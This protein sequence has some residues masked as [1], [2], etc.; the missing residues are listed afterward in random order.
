M[1]VLGMT[2]EG[3]RLSSLA[4]CGASTQDEEGI[5]GIFGPLFGT[6]RQRGSGDETSCVLDPQTGW[7]VNIEP[8]PYGRHP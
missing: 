5:K 4:I 1:G 8:G 3:Q 6:V 7:R 2:C